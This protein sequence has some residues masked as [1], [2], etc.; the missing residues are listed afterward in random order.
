MYRNV[1]FTAYV[2]QSGKEE[3]RKLFSLSEVSGYEEMR[4]L[5]QSHCIARFQRIEAFTEEGIVFTYDPAEKVVR[6]IKL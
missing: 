6:R 3:A 4:S 2:N 1:R 5:L